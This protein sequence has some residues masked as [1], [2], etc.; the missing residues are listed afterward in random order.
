MDVTSATAA[1]MY[2]DIVT[3]RYLEDALIAGISGAIHSV[4]RVGH[5][6]TGQEAVAAGACAALRQDDLIFCGHRM[7]HWAIAKGVDLGALVAEI[8]GKTT[9]LAGGMGGE[10]HN[11][12]DSI[13]YM[14][15]THMVAGTLPVA[16][17]CAMALKLQGGDNIVLAEYSDGA[18]P[19]G[20]W[21]EAMNLA[22]VYQVPVLFFLEN[23]Q[24]AESTPPIYHSRPGNFVEKAAGYGFPG[25]KV[26]G[27]DAFA[28]YEATSKTVEAMRRERT[29]RFIEAVTYRYYGHWYGDRTSRYR[30]AE[31]EAYWRGRDPV[32]LCAESAKQ[33]GLLS[34]DELEQ[35]RDQAKRAVATAI[36][37]ADESPFPDLADLEQYV[38]A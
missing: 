6:V 8:A 35:I 28:V 19:N 30:T 13:G 25:E 32:D 2:R 36:E 24:Y 22:S 10:M 33:R 5:P 15:P 31:E 11:Y 12:D 3:T 38:I 23:N 16:V 9:G 7:K 21:H 37:F 20:V 26:D 1:K 14:G 34:A 18:T 27:Q 29:P 4:M 17:G